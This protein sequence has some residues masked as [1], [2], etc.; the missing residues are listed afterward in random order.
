MRIAAKDLEGEASY[1]LMTGIVVPRPIAWVTTLSTAGGVNL[2]PF[3][4]FTVVSS[5]PPLLAFSVGHNHGVY[6]DTARNILA[7]EEYVIH[8]AD[9]AHLDALHQSSADY[10][11]DVSEVETLGLATVASEEIKVPRLRDA[12]VAMECRLRNCIEFGQTRNRLIV[13]EVIV[14]HF[15]DGLVGDGKVVTADLDPIARLGGPTYA[16]LGTTVTMTAL[17]R[18]HKP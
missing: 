14:F 6:K 16:R 10:P 4:M 9:F 13:G 7:L 17:H 8:I 18:T 3:S 2:A 12:P 11:P 15:R 1:R 5:K